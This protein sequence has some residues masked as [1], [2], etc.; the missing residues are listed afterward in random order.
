MREETG[1]PPRGAAAAT[2]RPVRFCVDFCIENEE[3]RIE[4][5]GFCTENGFCRRWPFAVP[6]RGKYELGIS[7]TGDFYIQDCAFKMTFFAGLPAPRKELGRPLHRPFLREEM[8]RPLTRNRRCESCNDVK[9]MVAVVFDCGFWLL[10]LIVVV[11]A[12]VDLPVHQIG[13]NR[14]KSTQIDPNQPQNRIN[15]DE[16]CI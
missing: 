10:F 1:W 11:L 15:N 4:N 9:C 12:W 7:K 13:P 16:F 6:V 3:F 8:G 5:K 2:T 14:P